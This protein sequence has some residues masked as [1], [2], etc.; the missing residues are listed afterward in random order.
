MTISNMKKHDVKVSFS[1]HGV[2]KI[3]A[4]TG[5]DAVRMVD[6]D[7]GMNI[8]DLT[9]G[10]LDTEIIDWNFDMM[11][12][13]VI[14]AA[15]SASKI[16]EKTVGYLATILERFGVYESTSTVFLD[17]DD[18]KYLKEYTKIF[19]G[20]DD[21]DWD[22]EYEGYWFDGNLVFLPQIIRGLTQSERDLW[23]TA[24]ALESPFFQNMEKEV[25][26]LEAWDRLNRDL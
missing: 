23:E 3:S 18:E 1:F 25:T 13:K 21:D 20:S 7:F 14:D 17:S 5:R 26:A 10:C 6:T 22:E 8:G 16:P 24:Q 19:R 12:T 9:T 4:K 15:T 2:V 11:A